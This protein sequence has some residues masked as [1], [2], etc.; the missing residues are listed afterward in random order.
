MPNALSLR[1]W[2]SPPAGERE[3]AENIRASSEE[4]RQ[5]ILG[6][7]KTNVRHPHPSLLLF[8][9][10]L[11]PPL[12]L[13]EHCLSG[14]LEKISEESLPRMGCSSHCACSLVSVLFSD[15]PSP[16]LRPASSATCPLAT[17]GDLNRNFLKSNKMKIFSSSVSLATFPGLN[18]YVQ[19]VV[20]M[21]DRADIEYFHGCRTCYGRG[22][23]TI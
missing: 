20:T 5:R 3:G 22:N 14:F 4:R 16:T 18:S 13:R 9:G 21:W 11:L 6:Q 2:T 23:I 8:G 15:L 19:L 12:P 17:Y 10:F 1:S 7:G